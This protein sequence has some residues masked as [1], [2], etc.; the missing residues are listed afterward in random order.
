MFFE[1]SILLILRCV[2]P[3]AMGS[4]VQ[5]HN[6]FVFWTYSRSQTLTDSNG[7]VSELPL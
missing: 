7:T 1:K 5:F 4:M 6:R 3:D 2:G